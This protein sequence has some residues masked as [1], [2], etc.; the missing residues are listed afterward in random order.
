M[1][2]SRYGISASGGN[3][4]VCSVFDSPTLVPAG[5]GDSFDLSCSL[6]MLHDLK[7]I[8]T[9]KILPEKKIHGSTPHNIYNS[10]V[11]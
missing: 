11:F 8:D 5:V 6:K 2:E 7:I 3:L 10:S 1:L 4:K 9:S